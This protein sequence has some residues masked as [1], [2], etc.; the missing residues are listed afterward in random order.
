MRIL[1]AEILRSTRKT[2]YVLRRLDDGST[3]FAR[4]IWKDRTLS[5]LPLNK[6]VLILKLGDQYNLLGH[7]PISGNNYVGYETRQ[8]FVLRYYKNGNLIIYPETQGILGL[9]V[10]N[11]S[12]Q[13][14]K[15][16]SS[17]ITISTR[18]L[19]EYLLIEVDSHTTTVSKLIPAAKFSKLSDIPR[20]T[21]RRWRLNGILTSTK[22]GKWG[23]SYYAP[24]QI[25]S[26]YEINRKRSS[27]AKMYKM[28]EE[29][30]AGIEPGEVHCY[31]FF[32]STITDYN[33]SQYKSLQAA[34]HRL[35]SEGY[36]ERDC[37]G[38]Y[39]SPKNKRKRRKNGY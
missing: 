35:V 7:D 31:R 15:F 23:Y 33:N 39:R 4:P 27:L 29:T 16:N 6:K 9:S 2:G 10:L 20:E 14:L 28:L 25:I 24:K 26:A 32:K 37:K 30:I 13:K 38:Y 5:K 8:N 12:S 11:F 34:L 1:T 17:M 3:I 19:P 18:S 22:I 36:L 21:L